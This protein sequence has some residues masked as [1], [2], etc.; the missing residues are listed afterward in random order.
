M[1]N[2]EHLRI[3]MQG[4]KAWNQWRR[5]NPEIK[6]DLSE[7]SFK[8]MS[9][10]KIYLNDANLYRADF[11]GADLWQ[12]L[13]RRTFLYKSNLSKTNLV[14]ANLRDSNLRRANLSEAN[15]SEANLREANLKQA[16]L[17][18]A[19]LSGAYIVGANL[20]DANLRG[21]NFKFAW[22]G[23]TTFA[24][25]DLSLA[26]ELDTIRHF[27]PSTIGVDTLYL[28]NGNIPELF[29]RNIGLPDNLIIYLSS[30]TG[31]AIDFYSCFI[32][33]SSKDQ[34]FADKLHSDLRNNG[35]SCWFAPEDLK[36]GEKIRTRIDESIRLHD[37]LLLVLSRSS[38]T[39]QWVEQEVEI[40]LAKEREQERVVLF[41]IR[42][43][44]TVMKINSG[45]PALIRNTR[46]IGDF[47]K[48]KNVDSYQKA[49]ERLV[50]DL[51]TTP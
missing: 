19:N 5:K 46:N 11:T 45:W 27:G 29:L 13:M 8:E 37:K 20:K 22:A 32:S 33:Y 26:L 1:A 6:P 38:V 23:G 49:F 14:D 3:F 10:R 34:Q 39:S 21:T 48:W 24:M 36:I 47:K 16:D 40:A 30:L 12:T 31:K 43:D 15:L 4:V 44:D 18:M 9:L 50:R 35:V 42:V 41:P 17:Y 7:G 28:S 51:K 2:K 25:N